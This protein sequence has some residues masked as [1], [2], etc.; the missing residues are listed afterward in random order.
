VRG[1][2][3]PGQT[4]QANPGFT[5][6]ERRRL[7]FMGAGLVVIVVAIVMAFVKANDY[8]RKQA[9]ETP[10]EDVAMAETVLLPDI[11]ANAIDALVK[12]SEQVERVVLEGEAVDY[13]LDRARTLTERH[14]EALNIEQLEA[15]EIAA[16]EA[17]PSAYR[18]Q[19]FRARGWV[20][21]VRSRYRGATNQQ[22]HIGR[23]ILEDDSVAYFLTLDLAELHQ[24]SFARI[25]GLFLKMFSD[26]D[27]SQGRWVDGPLLVGPG[28]IRSYRDQGLVT[29]LEPGY[30]MDVEDA[31]LVPE[32]G[33][34]RVY[35][36]ESPFEALWHLM[37]FA[38]N[39][40]T[41][42][43]D[44]ESAPLLD[45]FTLMS[46]VD[47]PA[48]WRGSPVRI[49]ISRIQDA[50]VLK[51]AENPARIEHFTQ[52]WIGNTTWKNVLFFKYPRANYD[53]KLRDHVTGRGF[54][55]HNF[56][57]P[58]AGKGL[59]VAPVFVLQ[60]LERFEPKPDPIFLNL[61]YGLAGIAALLILLFVTL[62]AR[63]KRKAETL[64]QEIVHRRRARQARRPGSGSQGNESIGPASP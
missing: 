37:A 43:I 10:T 39:V 9:V 42:A 25:D 12:D 5:R 7:L 47:N 13:L 49:P 54:F 17:D 63:D 60:E 44:W 29:T 48:E 34:A 38:R 16:I 22:E 28:A 57:Y 41:E 32:D 58:S 45:N 26:E 4:P 61:G 15:A 1:F 20:Q 31:N 50:R 8:R 24:D 6:N 2:K 18:G 64:R 52:G 19:A 55:L 33:A 3:V 36:D 23:L 46:V 27:V 14:F 40:P 11:D 62:L 30:L 56:S 53:L 35:A 51:A 59:R 21:T